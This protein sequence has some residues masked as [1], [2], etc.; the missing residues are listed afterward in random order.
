MPDQTF[1]DWYSNLLCQN[2]CSV[3][4]PIRVGGEHPDLVPASVIIQELSQL[5]EPKKNHI[6]MLA[7]MDENAGE[8]PM[9][10][11]RHIAEGMEIQCENC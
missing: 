4:T 7:M 5:P 11:L 3:D 1:I 10:L 9:R 6:K 2:G 8:S